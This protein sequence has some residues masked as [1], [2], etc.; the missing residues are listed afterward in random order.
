MARAIVEGR[1]SSSN[2][3][4][5]SHH[6]VGAKRTRAQGGRAVPR[7]AENSSSDDS[8]DE[9]ESDEQNDDK[10]ESIDIHTVRL[11]MNNRRERQKRMNAPVERLPFEVFLRY[12]STMP[13]WPEDRTSCLAGKKADAPAPAP[14]E[15][16]PT[17]PQETPS[18]AAIVAERRTRPWSGPKRPTFPLEL[19]DVPQSKFFFNGEK[20]QK[21]YR[22]EEDAALLVWMIR[23]YPLFGT[24]PDYGL[25]SF[26]SPC[27]WHWAEQNSITNRSWESMK[28]RARNTLISYITGKTELPQDVW[29]L[30]RKTSYFRFSGHNIVGFDRDRIDTDNYRSATMK[31]AAARFRNLKPAPE[32]V[33]KSRVSRTPSDNASQRQNNG[34][35]HNTESGYQ[36]DEEE[37]DDE[38]QRGVP[39]QTVPSF[40]PFG[41]STEEDDEEEEDE[42]DKQSHFPPEHPKR[43]R[44]VISDDEEE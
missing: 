7:A 24:E 9:R 6:G 12:G 13:V 11:E 10:E 4:A 44:V 25:T 37:E 39:Q 15:T 3:V 31:D 26:M 5:T 27:L 28:S 33:P 32:A 42:G 23:A 1:S 43:R 35:A 30:L 29:E 40:A 34:R 36:S 14:R 17:A 21:R 38:P 19:L 22:P 2:R 16:R 20:G 18:D 41:R 8:D